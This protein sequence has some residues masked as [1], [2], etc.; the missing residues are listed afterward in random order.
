[1]FECGQTRT[2]GARGKGAGALPCVRLY[3]ALDLGE[4]NLSERA[5]PI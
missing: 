4:R 2:A 1:M 5:G 3:P